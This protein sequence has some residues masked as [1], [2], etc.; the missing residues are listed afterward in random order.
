MKNLTEK[1]KK[2]LDYVRENEGKNI[3]AADIAE[4][5]G[6]TPQQV[7]G[8]ITGAFV[9]NTVKDENGDKIAQPLMVRVPAE[10]E[11]PDGTHKAIKLIK[12][13]EDGR[14]FD[15]SSVETAE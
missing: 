1:S 3:T 9:R 4:A 14:A 5:L 15:E 2:V 10:I 13:T 8:T 11:L 6:M 12:L 7:N